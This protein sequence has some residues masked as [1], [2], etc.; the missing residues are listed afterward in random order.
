MV[1]IWLRILKRNIPVV[2]FP[3][4]HRDV[5]SNTHRA[6]KAC[7]KG[8]LTSRCPAGTKREYSLQVVGALRSVRINTCLLPFS[9]HGLMVAHCFPSFLQPHPLCSSFSLPLPNAMRCVPSFFHARRFCLSRYCLQTSYPLSLPRLRFVPSTQA[10]R[11]G[12]ARLPPGRFL[13]LTLPTYRPPRPPFP[14]SGASSGLCGNR[15]RSMPGWSK[16]LCIDDVHFIKTTSHTNTQINSGSNVNLSV[17]QS[18][19]NA[20]WSNSVFLKSKMYPIPNL[21]GAEST[22]M[23]SRVRI[24]YRKLST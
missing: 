11:R 17:W 19:K 14:S 3:I 8:R 16:A 12:V 4:S 18:K 23:P 13:L 22:C 7:P 15:G 10:G 24:R 5:L 2:F 1:L 6:W 9:L 20:I 21:V